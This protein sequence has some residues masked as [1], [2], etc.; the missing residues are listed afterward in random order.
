VL[1]SSEPDKICTIWG[2]TVNLFDTMSLFCSFLIGF[3]PKYHITHDRSLNLRPASL[4]N[5]EAGK[6]VLYKE[7]LCRM[8]I[9]G[10]TNLN[11]DMV[12]LAGYPLSK[13]LYGQLVKYLQEVIPAMDQVL[14]D[15]MLELADANQ[16]AGKEGMVGVEGEEEV[17]AIMGR[18]Y[19]VRPFRVGTVGMREL[20]PSGELP[21]CLLYLFLCS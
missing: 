2:M 14:K 19:K 17:K 21:F 10:K 3:K 9:T 5:P 16:Q 8:R 1:P 12:N 15:L 18:V 7:Y 6:R 13:K 11:L 4:P 20:N